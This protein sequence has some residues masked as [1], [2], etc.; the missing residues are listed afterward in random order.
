MFRPGDPT[1]EGAS[2]EQEAEPGAPRRSWL[3]ASSGRLPAL[4]VALAVIPA[5]VIALISWNQSRML[6][7]KGAGD[8]LANTA[9]S[10][11][12]YTES[13]FENFLKET[14][15]VSQYPEIRAMN[16][17]GSTALLTNEVEAFSPLYRQALLADPRGRVIAAA[18]K[19]P[20]VREEV[21]PSDFRGVD[22]RGEDWF[23]DALEEFD[24]SR[25][26]A[27]LETV[28]YRPIIG[29]VEG[30]GSKPPAPVVS[31]AV[32]DGPPGDRRV[33]GVLAL[34][35]NWPVLAVEF[36]E[37]VSEQARRAG[38][39]G[40]AGLLVDREGRTLAGPD[41]TV[42]LDTDFS[43]DGVIQKAFEEKTAGWVRYYDDPNDGGWLGGETIGAYDTFSQ[44]FIDQGIDWAWII[45]QEEKDALADTEGLRTNLILLTL[46]IAIAAGLI[47]LLVGRGLAS[48]A[49]RLRSSAQEV[50]EGAVSLK[51]SAEKG[52]GRAQRTAELASDQVLGLEDMRK[53]VE[54]MRETGLRIGDSAKLVAEQAGRAAAAG[55]EGRTAAIEV[56]RSMAEID[57]RV[58]TLASEIGAL[59]RQTDQIGEIIATVS[60]IA[61]QSNLLA[62]NATIEAAKAGEHGAGFS[63]VAEE[64]RTLAEQSKRATA[65]IRSILSEID[66]A[67]QEAQRSA[68]EGIEA[69]ESGRERAESAAR[70]IE[71][72]AE[73][74]QEA[75][76]TTSEIAGLAPAQQEE[77][78]RV[79]S[80][81]EESLERATKVRSEAEES[82]HSTAELDRLAERLREL[83]STLTGG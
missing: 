5:A 48:R 22:V 9:S 3:L 54:D 31:I 49:G 17:A 38:K 4:L 37:D 20:D 82:A 29:K 61:D 75:E 80:A 52:R 43:K 24:G 63:V 42:A 56:D 81:A 83:S 66:R 72:L 18:T 47:A 59:T 26:G 32:L 60:S 10:L 76:K 23:R 41:G 44:S 77:S 67:T 2:E 58:R 13:S 11:V 1:P 33:A 16:P 57:E 19:P 12:G 25:A 34:F 39:E 69:V 45:G 51:G 55:E 46:A 36:S 35:P 65:Q 74:N 53:R 73:A 50:E 71:Q 15:A 79:I 30:S 64:V 7:E 6:L 28:E 62:F 21:T 68:V 14:E 40:V 70:T 8:S 27:S 78:A